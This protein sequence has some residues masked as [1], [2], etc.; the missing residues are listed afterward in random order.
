MFCDMSNIYIIAHLW[1]KGNNS[2]SATLNTEKQK[3]KKNKR[4]AIMFRI[5]VTD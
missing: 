3:K 5:I 1:G 4:H 2:C